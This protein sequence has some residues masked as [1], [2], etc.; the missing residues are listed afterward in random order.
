MS[1]F[2]KYIDKFLAPVRDL[3]FNRGFLLGNLGGDG[4]FVDGL[5]VMPKASLS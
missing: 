1:L 4:G 2:R 3:L 5:A